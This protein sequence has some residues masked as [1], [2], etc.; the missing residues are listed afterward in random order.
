MLLFV[1]LCTAFLFIGCEE[2]TVGTDDPGI[3]FVLADIVGTWNFPDQS[4]DS[5]I[6]VEI[7]TSPT[8]GIFIKWADATYVYD[9]HGHGTL[10]DKVFS[11]TYGYTSTIGGSA[12]PTSDVVLEVALTFSLRN[13]RLK[14]TF[15]GEGPLDG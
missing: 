4:G 3:D 14:G 15:S 8:T 2:R 6:T 10:E 13:D 1:L 12:G 11:Y 5:A 9:C 7:L